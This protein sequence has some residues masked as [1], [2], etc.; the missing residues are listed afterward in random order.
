[1]DYSF[2]NYIDDIV[3]KNNSIDF[4]LKRAW[5]LYA[6]SNSNCENVKLPQ[7]RNIDIDSY[8][9]PKDIIAGH[10]G[11]MYQFSPTPTHLNFNLKPSPYNSVWPKYIGNVETLNNV[12][13]TEIR[14]VENSLIDYFT[15]SAKLIRGSYINDMLKR[16]DIL[17]KDD[18]KTNNSDNEYQQNLEN[19][20]VKLYIL[21]IKYVKNNHSIE[22]LMSNFINRYIN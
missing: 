2:D 12:T 1:M 18:V 17:D 20:I 15:K 11:Y 6:C 10:I 9:I 22:L 3:D 8:I 13:K 19:Y 5:H 14:K 4:N 7:L 16:E 21:N